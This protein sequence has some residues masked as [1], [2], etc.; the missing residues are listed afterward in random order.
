MTFFRENHIINLLQKSV[1]FTTKARRLRRTA[2][3]A[4]QA[5]FKD[6]RK[7]TWRLCAFEAWWFLNGLLMQEV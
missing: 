1:F 2:F 7:K 4:V 6:Q 5:S 3:V